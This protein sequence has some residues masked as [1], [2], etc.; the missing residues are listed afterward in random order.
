MPNPGVQSQFIAKSGGNQFNGEYYLDWYNNSLQGS[1]IPDEY[2]V[3]TAFNNSPIRAH[4]NE[5]DRYYDTAINVGGPIKKD[6]IWWFGTY[7][8]QFNAIQQPNFQF[9]KTFD[10]KLWNAV[11]KGTYQV[12]QKHKIVGYYQ[13]GQKI[14]PNRLPQATYTYLD[15][16]PTNRQ[17]S[18]SWVYK[19]RME[20]HGQRQA[21]SSKPATATSATTSRRSPTAP[22][23][24]TS[25]TRARWKS[26]DRTRRTRTIAI[27]S[28]GTSRRTYF[29]DSAKGSHTFKMGAEMLKEL[30]WFGVLQGVGGNIE[31][32]YN[33]GVSNQVIFRIP[34]A[35]QVG[36]L[37]DN[38]NGHLTTENALDQISVFLN[39]T[40]SVGASR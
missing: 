2:T 37:K 12:N 28:S 8:T 4:S 7:R 6:K 25:A 33:N 27:A 15:E 3:P 38:D 35:T 21:V 32:V 16:G 1:N 5:I 18:G 17:D 31:H 39:D 26:P 11:G 40:W 20:R 19:A 10:T 13:W 30:Q 36:G 22:S 9:D 24:I 14:Q 29:L 34:T 23:R